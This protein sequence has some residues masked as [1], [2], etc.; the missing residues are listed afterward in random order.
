[1]IR[2]GLVCAQEHFDTMSIGDFNKHFCKT[3]IN[4]PLYDNVSVIFVSIKDGVGDYCTLEDRTLHLV[5]HVKPSTE[6]MIVAFERN[7]FGEL[8]V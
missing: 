2:A 7:Y 8:L 1:M 6:D 4:H 3:V 5:L